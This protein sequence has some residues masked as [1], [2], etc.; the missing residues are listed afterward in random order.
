MLYLTM[1]TFASN[2]TKKKKKKEK[3]RKIKITHLMVTLT[4]ESDPK[5]LEQKDW[6]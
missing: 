3:K 6:K 1:K 5:I 4:T 2:K